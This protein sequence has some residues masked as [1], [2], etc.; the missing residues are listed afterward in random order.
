MSEEQTE[1][2]PE[3]TTEGLHQMS[4]SFDAVQDRLL[5]RIGTRG[6]VEH[7]LWL[8]R[9]FVKMMWAPVLKILD[10]DPDVTQEMP[11]EAR[12]FM[13]AW[14]HQ[15]SV[16]SGGFAKPQEE[17][18][19][20][21]PASVDPLLVVKAQFKPLDDGGSQLVFIL[22]HGGALTLSLNRDQLHAFCHLTVNAVAKAGWQIDL[23]IGDAAMALPKGDAVVH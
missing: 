9:R 8:T 11:A 17:V 7:R 5:F 15:E 10:R 4:M 18:P 23:R 12:E 3:S 13:R 19:E 20:N 16:S 6:N 1:K 21:R 2:A 22:D 14:K